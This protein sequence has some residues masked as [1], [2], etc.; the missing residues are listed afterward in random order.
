[1][2]RGSGFIIVFNR[3]PQLIAAVE[4]NSRSAPKRVADRIAATARTLVPVDTGALRASIESV[5]VE[6]GKEADVIVGKEYGIYVELGTYKMAAQPFLY[7]AVQQHADEL[8]AE[9][10]VPLK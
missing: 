1:M 8:A 2:A 5:S 6:A 9:L 4:A 10:V 7:P 3:I